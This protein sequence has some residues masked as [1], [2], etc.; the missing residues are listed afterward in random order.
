MTLVIVIITSVI[1]IIA[2][3]NETLMSR[4]MFNPYQVY[5]RKELW[6]LITHGFLH[7]DWIHL[8]INMIVFYSFGRN[9]EAWMFQLKS[10]G[11]IRSPYF[12]Y[13]LLYFGGIIVSTLISLVRHHKN[14]FYNSVGAS[15]AVSAI[16]FTSIFFSPLERIYFFAAIPIPG[17]VFAVIYLVYSS[18]MSRRSQDNIN[19]DAHFAGAIFGFIFPALIS[20]KLISHFLQS[21]SF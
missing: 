2:F 18:F 9:V 11:Y 13:S 4:F 20:V 5:Y 7:A 14:Y 1:S 10:A 16:I 15:G 19:H 6:R 17:I 8:I 3:Y 21:F 12:T